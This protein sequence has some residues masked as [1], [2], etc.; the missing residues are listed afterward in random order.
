MRSAP[1][2]SAAETVLVTATQRAPA[3]LAACTP[4]GASSNTTQRRASRPSRPI[5]IRKICGSGFFF[6]TS[7]P[8]T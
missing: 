5:A 8:L 3:A 6:V 7:L 1:A 4:L 2:S